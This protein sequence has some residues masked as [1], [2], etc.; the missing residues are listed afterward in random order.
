[1]KNNL[2]NNVL[3]PLN[4]FMK[5]YT[6]NNSLEVS[7]VQGRVIDKIRQYQS[8]LNQMT[9]PAQLQRFDSLPVQRTVSGGII[10]TGQSYSL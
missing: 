3:T 8:L 4:N 6:E 2:W 5:P 7:D 10:G 9:Q 1:M